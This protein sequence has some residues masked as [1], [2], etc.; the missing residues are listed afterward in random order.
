VIMTIFWTGASSGWGP[1]Q[2]L[3]EEDGAFE[4]QCPENDSL[5]CP[6][7]TTM[8]LNVKFH[9]QL[10]LILSPVF[11]IFA[12]LYGPL[13]LITLSTVFLIAG[14]GGVILMVA[15]RYSAVHILFLR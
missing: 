5:P 3:L 2:L 6:A 4:D 11:G 9:A 14:S 7:Q 12:D 13:C 1:M 15:R 10:T 8:L